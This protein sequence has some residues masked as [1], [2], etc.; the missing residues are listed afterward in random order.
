MAFPSNQYFSFLQPDDAAGQ[1]QS[2]GLISDSHRTPL[3][4]RHNRYVEVV[5]QEVGTACECLCASLNGLD[6]LG[7]RYTVVLRK[8]F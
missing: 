4:L 8:V 7:R 3:L 6:K 1:A 2:N 5:D